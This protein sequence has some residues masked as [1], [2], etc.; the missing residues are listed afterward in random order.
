MNGLS[1]EYAKAVAAPSLRFLSRWA[2]AT[3]LMVVGLFVV[4]F[5][6]IGIASTD[7][8]LGQQYVELMQAVR[9]PGLYR[10]FTILDALAWLLTGGSLLVLAGICVSRV[11]IQAALIAACGIGQ[12]TGSLGGFMRLDGISDLAVR[13]ASS[14]PDQQAAV[15]QSYLDLERIIGA[16]FH[17]GNLLQGVGFLLVAWAV[18]SH[19]SFPRWLGVWFAVP[20]LLPLIQFALVAAGSPFSFPLL[21]VHLVIGLLGLHVALAWT[22]WRP[23]SALVS[24]L[25][26]PATA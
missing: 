2:L 20:G 12:L 21:L 9:N 14:A 7:S 5:G 24:K 15:L 17:A 22:L 19:L 3:A 4:F 6:G 10:V 11:P 26:N 1:P 16:H 25:S 8:A 18:L 23:S 13:Y